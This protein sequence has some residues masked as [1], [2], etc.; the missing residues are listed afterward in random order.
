[1]TQK[2]FTGEINKN[3]CRIIIIRVLSSSP[4]SSSSPVLACI[5]RWLVCRCP[6][7]PFC[8]TFLNK[9]KKKRFHFVATLQLLLLL[10]LIKFNFSQIPV[11]TFV[12]STFIFF[13]CCLMTDDHLPQCLLIGVKVWT[14]NELNSGPVWCRLGPP[15]LVQAVVRGTTYL[16]F[17][18]RPNKIG[19]FY[20]NVFANGNKA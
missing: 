7:L 17:R 18:F 19:A 8:Q 12:S 6:T 1:M 3:K 4:T 16:L 13:L 20:L 5:I 2:N 11:Q 15:T 14:T 10:L 9:K